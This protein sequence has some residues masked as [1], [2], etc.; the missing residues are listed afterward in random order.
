MPYLDASSTDVSKGI[1]RTWYAGDNETYVDL[2]EQ[3]AKRWREWE[4]RFNTKFYHQVG[5]I[6]VLDN[7][8]TGTPMHASVEFLRARGADVEVLLRARPRSA[9]LSSA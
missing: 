8:E 4:E 1:R 5:G 9:S 3:A 2:V 6:I 7:L